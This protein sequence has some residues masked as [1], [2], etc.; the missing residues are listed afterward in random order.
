MVP[1]LKVTLCEVSTSAARPGVSLPTSRAPSTSCFLLWEHLAVAPAA[2]APLICMPMQ[3]W[4]SLHLQWTEQGLFYL[5]FNPTPTS[6]FKVIFFEIITY[7][8]TLHSYSVN[9]HLFGAY[10]IPGIPTRVEDSGQIH[11]DPKRLRDF[12]SKKWATN[13]Y[14]WIRE[15]VM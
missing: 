13:V 6:V 8:N 3:R 15:N 11:K 1:W 12:K 9:F 7:W 14:K 10:H 5:R 4:G 2:A